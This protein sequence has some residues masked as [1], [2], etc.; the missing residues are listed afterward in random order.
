MTNKVEGMTN[1]EEGMTNKV[2][3]MT[4]KDSSGDGICAGGYGRYGD[5]PPADGFGR[6]GAVAHEA[7][8]EFD[9]VEGGLVG[10][11]DR[12]GAGLSDGELGEIFGGKLEGAKDGGGAF[13]VE[14]A[15]RKGG[16]EEGCGDLDG[17]A[18]FNGR[19]VELIDFDLGICGANGAVAEVEAGVE[20]APVLAG[21]RGRVAALSVGFDVAA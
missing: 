13:F 10:G 11:D 8:S 1:K 20:E 19:Q 14:V 5:A 15:G 7:R 12:L 4:N 9:A 21:G 2:E 17:F 16:D 18:V 3:G 6:G